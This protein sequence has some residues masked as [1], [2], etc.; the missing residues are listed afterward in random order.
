MIRKHDLH[1]EFPDRGEQITRLKVN[2]HHFRNLFEKY[3]TVNEE[4]HRIEMGNEVV[5]DDHLTELRKQRLQLK[6]E[7]YAIMLEDDKAEA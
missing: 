5:S 4:I 3:H 1:H 7:L 2:D 6:D